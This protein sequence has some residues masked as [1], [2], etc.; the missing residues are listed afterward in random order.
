LSEI[1]AF[2]YVWSSGYGARLR[3]AL[4]RR[5]SNAFAVRFAYGASLAAIAA[6]AA[7][8]ANFVHFRVDYAYGVTTQHALGW[9]RDGLVTTAVDALVV[10][11][12]VACVFALVD[13][14]RLW[15]LYAMA[16]LFVVTLL[17]AFLEPVIVAPLYNRFTPL[18][19]TSGVRVPLMGLAERAAIGNAP[20]YVADDSR[21]TSAAIAD[22]AGFG[23][24]KRIV[25]SD[26]LLADA[27]AGEV[28]FLAAREFG[29]Y[30]HHDDFRLS[31]FWTFLFIFCTALAVLVADRVAFRRD[32]D[33]LA[34]LSLVFG[35]LGS[36][37]LLAT[38]IYNGYSRNLESQADSYALALTHDRAAA[39]RAYVRIADETLAPLC[40]SRAVRLYFYNSPPL[41]TRIAKA[42]RRSDPCR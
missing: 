37:G 12:I 17:M 27:T 10:G 25:L 8:P 19:S 38:P 22:V 24:T 16:G 26:A 9:M 14:T 41:G 31:L 5:I 28:L 40:P 3:G 32:D 20:I 21:R 29:H 30:A 1:F 35:F 6:L 34:R 15:Y 11:A 23:P 33:P 4:R 39:V 42:A 36:F 18:S 2:F 7:L 13:R